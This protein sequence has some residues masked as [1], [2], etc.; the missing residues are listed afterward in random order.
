MLLQKMK[1][2]FLLLMVLLCILLGSQVWLKL[3]EFLNYDLE[4][5]N[6]ANKKEI[7]ETNIWNVVKPLKS[8]I[9]YKDN[10]TVLYTDEY[11]FWNKTV[12]ILTEGLKSYSEGN[13]SYTDSVVFPT[14]YLKL[15]FPTNMPIKIFTK[16]MGINNESLVDNINNIKNII[17]DLDKRNTIYIYNGVDTYKFENDTINTESINTTIE[18]LDF[19]KHTK[20]S[21]DEKI[22]EDK[23]NIPLPLEEYALNPV[24]VQSELDVFDTEEINKIAKNY[25]KNNYEYVRKSVELNG[26]RVYMYR[27]E[28]VL[29]IQAEGLL[30]FYNSMI[31]LEKSQDVY[32]SL[33]SALVFIEDFLGFPK[34]GYL[35][36]IEI[37]Q[38]EGTYGY[39]FTFSYKI[40]NRPIMFSKVRENAA[41]E[42]DVIGDGVVSY[43]RFIRNIDE[44]QRDEM[45]DIQVLPAIEVINKNLQNEETSQEEL[46]PLKKEMIKDISNVY[47]GYFDLSRISKEQ[48]LRVVWVVEI[49]NRS[50]IFNAIRGSLIEEW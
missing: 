12:S 38:Y 42:I 11:N 3:P 18:N 40:L 45:K 9:K 44:S 47:L 33:M 8:I 30:D 6:V 37:I 17:I 46:K 50:Y 41:L 32:D 4:K 5:D 28:K 19:N 10:Y 15:D 7:P 31:D 16:H 1:N 39:R 27:T 29:K 20:Y 24:F 13:I 2:L 22:G 14:Q 26:N 25:F 23:I 36:N 48:V 34:D 35:S 21:I 49:G 43:K